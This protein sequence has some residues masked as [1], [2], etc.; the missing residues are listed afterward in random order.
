MRNPLI[1]ARCA[2][3]H[4]GQS[5][6]ARIIFVHVQVPSQRG[7]LAVKCAVPPRVVYPPAHP[8][9]PRRSTHEVHY[10]SKDHLG[11]TDVITDAAG[12]VEVRSSSEDR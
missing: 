7:E 4:R 2:A 6:I 1:A 10:L 8:L 12:V 3:R 5:L 9:M 11:S